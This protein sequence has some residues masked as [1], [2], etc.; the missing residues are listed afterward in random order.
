M[1]RL[2]TLLLLAA[3]AVASATDISEPFS[4]DRAHTFD[5]HAGFGWW[6]GGYGETFLVG[7][8]YAIPIV[9]NGFI[10]SINNAVTITFGA[11]LYLTSY[12]EP[13]GNYYRSGGLGVPV[14]LAWNFYFTDQWSAFGEAG[15]NFYIGRDNLRGYGFRPGSNLLVTAAGG[16][17]HMSEKTALILRVGNPYSAFGVEFTL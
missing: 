6:G 7:G 2:L 1:S 14:T 4:G 3:P 15:A 12:I 8:R 13:N 9:D 5:L 17:Y 10:A 16:R 11:D